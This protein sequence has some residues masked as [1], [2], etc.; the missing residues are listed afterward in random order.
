MTPA[1]TYA[2]HLDAVQSQNSRIYGPSSGRD[3]WGA[4]AR[5][6]RFDPRREL[7]RNMLVIASYVQPDDIVADVGGGAGRVG[8]PLALQCKEVLNIEPSPGMGAEFETLVREANISNG[9]LIPSSFAEVQELTSDIVITADVT[10]FVRDIVAFIR[11]LEA[12][13]SR[14]VMITIWSEPPPN[15]SGDFF[16][17]VYGEKQAVLPGLSQLMPVLSDMGI[18]P[19]VHVMPANPWWENQP[20]SIKSDAVDMLLMDRVTKPEDREHVRLLIEDNFDRLFSI[21]EKGF[22]PIWRLDMRELLITWEIC[23]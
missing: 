14:R 23:D 21:G 5:Q 15:R 16:A 9:R 18:Y 13:A 1:E 4:A 10:Y 19:D 22:V 8:L 20:I 12:T 6:F 3:S 7:D 17:L 11:K 2:A